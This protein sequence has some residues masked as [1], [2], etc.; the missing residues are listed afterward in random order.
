MMD[1][2]EHGNKISAHISQE[3]V[4]Q[5]KYAFHTF[6]NFLLHAAID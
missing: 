3:I 1:T 2:Y 5:R 4:R 6:E